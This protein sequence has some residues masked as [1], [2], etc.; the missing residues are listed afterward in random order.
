MKA[1]PRTVYLSLLISLL[2]FQNC[3]QSQR[4]ETENDCSVMAYYTRDDFSSVKKIDA[5]VHVRTGDSTLINQAKKDNFYLLTINTDELPGI[6]AQDK[7]AIQQSNTFPE[8]IAYAATFSVAN[9]DDENWQ[10]QTIA[11]L[12]KSFSAGAIAVKIY[13]NIGMELSDKNGKLVM[14]DDKRFDPV[15][16]YIAKRNIP[17]VGHLGE[18]KNCWLPVDQ[19]TINGDKSYFKRHPEFHMYLHPEFPSYEE[20]IAARDEM[21][22]KH[23]DLK[24]IGAHLGS[25]EWSL[26]ELAGHLDKFPNMSLDM[27]ARV[28]HIQLHA[29]NNW[30]KTHDFFI[31]YQDRIIYGTDTIVDEDEDE[32][33]VRTHVHDKWLS[34]WQFFSTDETAQ[35]TSFEGEFKGLKLPKEVIDKIFY[36]NAQRVFLFPSE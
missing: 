24:F 15:I 3:T 13:K 30:Q 33:K 20:Q 22:K 23:P 1:I 29:L 17:I 11:S 2:F 19:M 7:F 12:K 4:T 16:D 10:D 25:M 21:L 14:I 6:E 36:R 26:D 8:Q 32:S 31:K 9:W 5:H 34:D 35:T 27:A 28:S 18:P